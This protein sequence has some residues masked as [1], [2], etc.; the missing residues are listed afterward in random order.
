V[1]FAL[2]LLLLP[3]AGLPSKYGS[4]GLIEYTGQLPSTAPNYRAVH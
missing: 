1:L 3:A 2:L 4:W